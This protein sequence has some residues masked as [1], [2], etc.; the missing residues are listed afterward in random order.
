MCRRLVWQLDSAWLG[1]LES[2]E[3][4]NYLSSI[5]LARNSFFFTQNCL[6]WGCMTRSDML[7]NG[8]FFI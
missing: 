8:C 4:F 6:H 5:L 1:A 3:N 2:A 7:T